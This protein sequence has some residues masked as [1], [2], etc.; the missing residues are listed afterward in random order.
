M[1]TPNTVLLS[2]LFYSVATALGDDG[3]VRVIRSAEG[4]SIQVLGDKDDDWSFEV[5][6][7][8]LNWE[9]EPALGTLLSGRSTNAPSK[10]LGLVPANRFYRARQTEGLYD[11]IALR[12]INLTFTQANWQTLLTSGREHRQQCY[13]RSDSG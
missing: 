8:L 1:K 4:P 12:T 11:P 7:D 9:N 5:S 13:R 3:Q 6:S 10:T 2:I